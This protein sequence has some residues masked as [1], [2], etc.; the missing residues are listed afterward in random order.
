MA[1]RGRG[2]GN[3]SRWDPS[4]DGRVIASVTPLKKNTSQTVNKVDSLKSMLSSVRV[5]CIIDVNHFWAQLGKR[6]TSV[7]VISS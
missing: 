2:R 5:T 4:F 7:L 1:G 6:N 3:I